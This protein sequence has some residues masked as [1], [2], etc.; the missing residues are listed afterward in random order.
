MSIYTKHTE[1]FIKSV[2]I[3][4]GTLDLRTAL[5]DFFSFLKTQMPIYALQFTVMNEKTLIH[6][7]WARVDDSGV[8]LNVKYTPATAEQA[9]FVVEG[10]WKMLDD[11]KGLLINN[12][13]HPMAAFVENLTLPVFRLILR[14][15]G[16][17][18]GGATFFFESN[19]TVTEEDTTILQA[20]RSPLF[21]AVTNCRRYQELEAVKERVLEENISLRRELN[22]MRF[23]NVVGADSGLSKVIEKARL[24]APVDTPVLIT[25]ETGTGKEV[26]ARTIHDLSSRSRHPFIAVNCGAIPATLIDSELFGHNKGAFTGA[27]SDHKGRF[28]RADGGTLFLDEISELPLDVQARLLRILQEKVLEKVGGNKSIP[29]DFRL[30]A[31]TNCDLRQKVKEG[32]FR[33]DLF[34]RL[35]VLPIEL[36]PL[37]ERRQDIP[38]L[39]THFAEKI[40]ARWKIKTP[41]VAEGEM[42]KLY[43]YAWPGN[44]R[45]LQNVVEEA[46]VLRP[47]GDLR[48]SN[49]SIETAASGNY[50]LSHGQADCPDFNTMQ[51]NYFKNLLELCGGHIYGHDGAAAKA[52]MHPNT[53]RSRLDKLKLSYKKVRKGSGSI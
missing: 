9:R 34:Y 18:L 47:N 36:P 29:I 30:I 33:E 3:L 21:S 28:E 48:F 42:E 13:S 46:M 53:L 19:Y 11:T 8:D 45:E 6:E 12:A 31:A 50:T 40:A 51:K 41:L 27:V 49:V 14:N 10:A 52:G 22:G 39:V 44:V 20:L 38:L 4:C 35:R 2:D 5:L 17:P 32:N 37:R 43:H 7:R 26:I 25:G 24:V 23:T 16:E 15:A 1:I